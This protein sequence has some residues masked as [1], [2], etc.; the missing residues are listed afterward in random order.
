MVTL[1]T[2]IKTPSYN[3]KA[4][5]V[6]ICRMANK[7]IVM[8]HKAIEFLTTIYRVERE[9][10]VFVDHGVP[11]IQLNRIKSREEFNLE[12]KKVLL[13]FGFIGRNKG[14]ETVIKALPKIVEKY[15]D[16]LY[17]VLGKTHPNVLRY[18][19][20]E[21][22]NYLQQLVKSLKLKIM[23]SFLTSTL[24]RRKYLNIYLQPIFTL[25]PTSMRPR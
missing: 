4:I 6:E 18:S 1:H 23:F 25:H 24:I 11:N 13:T 2:I 19:G 21:Y 10:I 3:Q 17:M 7:I 5:L 14:I 16:V 12:N 9:K 15:P 8:S 20:E 22:R